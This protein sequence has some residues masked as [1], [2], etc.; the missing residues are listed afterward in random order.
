VEY[1]RSIIALDANTNQVARE[2]VRGKVSRAWERRPSL[3]ART[4]RRVIPALVDGQHTG[5]VEADLPRFERVISSIAF[6]VYFRETGARWQRDWLVYSS[7]MLAGR[8]LF[9]G[10]PDTLN[11][12]LRRTLAEIPFEIRD[13][14][15]PAVFQYAVFREGLDD[16]L[17]RFTF[18]EGAVAYAIA[19]C[20]AERAGPAA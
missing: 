12:S 10:R 20:P 3:K 18:Y 6:A 11:P 16:L 8:L 17:Y 15:Q 4:F 19:S 7:T 2:L 1:T 14:P 5:I 9:E 13:V